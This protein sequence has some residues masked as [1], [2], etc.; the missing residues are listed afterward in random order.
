M[1]TLTIELDDNIFSKITAF[2]RRKGKSPAEIVATV[3]SE[4]FQEIEA[5]DKLEAAQLEAKAHLTPER[6]ANAFNEIRALNTPPLLGDE[7]PVLP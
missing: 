6:L 4:E 3:T 7:M 5:M 2:A 1:N